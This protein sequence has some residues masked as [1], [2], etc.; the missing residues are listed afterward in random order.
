VGFEEDQIRRHIRHQEQLDA[1]G[2][3]EKEKDDD[4]SEDDS[5]F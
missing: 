5:K 3:D 2:Y 4:K 1:R